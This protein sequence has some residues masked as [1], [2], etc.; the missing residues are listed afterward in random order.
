MMVDADVL[1]GGDRLARVIA[2]AS[3][4]RVVSL[5]A[6]TWRRVALRTAVDEV[7]RAGRPAA[8]SVLGQH[9][10]EAGD[11]LGEPVLDSPEADPEV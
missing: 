2:G 11:R 1:S 7:R 4:C 6:R 10:A 3:A 9:L 8:L 5:R